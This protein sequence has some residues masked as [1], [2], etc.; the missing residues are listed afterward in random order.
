MSGREPI[1]FMSVATPVNIT[2]SQQRQF[3]ELGYIILE[4]VIPPALLE[5]LRSECDHAV[6]E[7]DRQMD[8]AGT[9]VINISHRGKR[10][11]VSQC[12]GERQRL[13]TFL[14]GDLMAKVCRA[15]LGDEADLHNDQFVVKGRDE[16][17]KFSWHQDSGYVG[18]HVG[19]HRPFLTCWCALDDA[20]EANGSIYV[21][22]FDRAGTRQRVEHVI[23][24]GTNDKVGYFGDD[25]GDLVQAPAGSIVAFASTLFHRSGPNLTEHLRRVY[26]AIYSAEPIMARDG[27]KPLY[28]EDPFLS[29]GNRVDH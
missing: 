24:P 14:F 16:G 11:F 26:L 10:Y 1:T 5:M 2:A 19:D 23:E 3:H 28:F 25:P 21:L 8:E 13:R 6:A 7:M 20:H 29:G 4:R 22:P 17:M 9:E 18:H 15:T 27:S 12:A